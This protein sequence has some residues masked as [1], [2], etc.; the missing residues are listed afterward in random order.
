MPQ[1]SITYDDGSVIAD[2]DVGAAIRQGKANVNPNADYKMLKPDG[3]RVIIKGADLGAAIGEGYEL[4]GAGEVRQQELQEKHGD[5]GGELKTFA[6]GAAETLL[7]GGNWI[8]DAKQAAERAEANPTARTAGE[9][10]GAIAP[11]LA[12]RGSVGGSTIARGI[13]GAARWSVPGMAARAGAATEGFVGR[14]LARTIAKGGVKG[15]VAKGA[16]YAAGGAVEGA[17]TGAN[18]GLARELREQEIRGTRDWAAAAERMWAGAKGGAAFGSLVGGAFGAGSAALGGLTKGVGKAG[19]AVLGKGRVAQVADDQALKASGLK[20]GQIKK[21]TAERRTQIANRLRKEGVITGSLDDNA[22]AIVK[23]A[24]EAGEALGDIRRALDEAGAAGPDLRKMAQRMRAEVLDPAKGDLFDAAGGQAKALQKRLIDRLEEAAAAQ[25]GGAAYRDAATAR[26]SFREVQKARRELDRYIW[27][28]EKQLKN[29]ELFVQSRRIIEEEVEN[30]VERAGLEGA[31]LATYKAAKARYRD[32]ANVADEA[33]KEIG[34]RAGNNVLG[35]PDYLAGQIG[36]M[37]GS[38]LGPAGAVAAGF[39]TSAGS[40]WVRNRSDTLI[41]RLYDNVAR[42]DRKVDGGVKSFLSAKTKGRL[43]MARLGATGAAAS[44]KVERDAKKR[45]PLR[46]KRGESR[47]DAYNRVVDQL[48]KDAADPIRAAER[49]LGGAGDVAPAATTAAAAQMQRANQF[50]LSK[51]PKTPGMAVGASVTP[52]LEKP[53]VNPVELERFARYVR[54]VDDPTTLL[55][56]LAAGKVSTESVEAIRTVYPD[57]YREIQTKI[58]DRLATAKEKPSYT[59]RTQLGVLFDVPTDP[60]LK[61]TALARTAAIYAPA[62]P[63]QPG[64]QQ[65]GAAPKKPGKAPDIA[66]KVMTGPDAI[67]SGEMDV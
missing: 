28:G 33:S 67:S 34:Q 9:V 39:A 29:R 16:K 59:Q 62:A 13:R 4:R 41:S 40:K 1:G 55:D 11:A 38:A 63:G 61:P 46:P 3:S 22:R 64:G 6:E 51:A 66:D 30:A 35:L 14:Q 21:M 23:K 60:S 44:E 49:R 45:D 47:N 50:L 31:D 15:A 43:Q 52:H 2:A 56:D 8:S 48:Q 65:A 36:A 20:G 37:A 17:I 5:L 10:A 32:L 12:S 54:A 42:V 58:M 25:P 57:M 53:R 26:S 24:E 27:S 19:Q 18:V 7:P